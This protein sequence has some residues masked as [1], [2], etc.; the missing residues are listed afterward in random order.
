MLQK[1]Q[2][3]SSFINSSSSHLFFSLLHG[4]GFV[5]S[6]YVLQS[7]SDN[8]RRDDWSVILKR[9]TTS[10]IFTAFSL[11]F[12]FLNSKKSAKIDLSEFFLAKPLVAA[13][14][15]GTLFAGVLVEWCVHF[16]ARVLLASKEKKDDADDGKE[17]T[18]TIFPFLNMKNSLFF[19]TC[20]RDLGF[21]PLTEEVVFRG[22]IH[23][24]H[25]QESGVLSSSSSS[26]SSSVLRT[27]ISSTIFS[28]AHIHHAFDKVEEIEEGKRRKFK[29]NKRKLIG[30]A[31]PPLLFGL[32]SGAL[33]EK[34]VGILP[35]ALGHSFCNLVGPPKWTMVVTGDDA[36]QRE[37]LGIA[38]HSENEESENRKLKIVNRFF[39]FL[40]VCCIGG[41]VYQCF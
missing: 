5:G 7:T 3:S 18:T 19:K 23:K 21:A 37:I 39:M 14:M 32:M 41:F 1:N 35:I 12:A 6:M 15:I 31:I 40:H 13:K 20:V 38:R 8:S 29:I 24:I 22:S 17:R 2:S 9:M 26:T 11:W 34:G 27:I 25:L 16:G 36:V 33:V 30:C 10:G 4:A 28:L